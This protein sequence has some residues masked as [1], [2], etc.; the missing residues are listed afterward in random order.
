[1]I[2]PDFFIGGVPKAGTTALWRYLQE[3]PD[4]YMGVEKEPYFFTHRWD[5][6]FDWYNGLYPSPN[7]AKRIGD[8]SVN[9]IYSTLAPARLHEHTPRAKLVFM[10]RNPI[11]RAFSDYWFSTNQG[12]SPY[13]K[14][15]FSELIR[16][17]E[18]PFR[19]TFMG[20][21]EYAA[22]MRRYT[23]AL[24]RAQVK[25]LFHEDFQART[26]AVVNDVF[27]YL[28]LPPAPVQVET[29]HNVTRFPRFPRV[30]EQVNKLKAQVREVL[31]ENLYALTRPLRHAISSRMLSTDRVHRATMTPEDR[32]YLVRYYDQEISRV[33]DY[34][35]RDLSSWRK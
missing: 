6:G 17:Q 35:G 34:T 11:E 18:D 32:E 16:A 19:A 12:L 31:P 23:D 10:L 8:G 7:G 30:Y 15:S 20:F 29:Q 33:E 24:S 26:A 4:V 13:I 1:M 21:G 22:G 28:D 9:L 3:H 25:V 14:Y 2:L 5:R 27:E